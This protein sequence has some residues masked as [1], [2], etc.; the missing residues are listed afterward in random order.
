[1]D[2]ILARIGGLD[3][4]ELPLEPVDVF[5]LDQIDGRATLEELA[6]AT[7]LPPERLAESIL[8][9]ET[10]GLIVRRAKA[11][12]P[13]PSSR[14]S[15]SAEPLR[16]PSAPFVA[17]PEA[18]PAKPLPFADAPSSPGEPLRDPPA[19]PAAARAAAEGP[20][21]DVETLRSEVGALCAGLPRIDHYRLLGVAPTAPFPDIRKR[22]YELVGRY[23][24]YRH[25]SKE[26]GALRDDMERLVAAL[27]TAYETLRSASARAAYDSERGLAPS[28]PRSDAPAAPQTP[29]SAPP[30]RS[31]ASD[32]GEANGS[33]GARDER[34][35]ALG[36]LLRNATSAGNLERGDRSSGAGLAR[37]RAQDGLQRLS[38]ERA[39]SAQA[40]KFQA[41][42]DA[43]L[44]EGDLLSAANALQARL[45]LEPANTALARRA[46]D[47]RRQAD[48]KYSNVYAEQARKAFEEG[49]LGQAAELFEKAGHGAGDQP[50]LL[51]RAAE[52]LLDAGLD[53]KRALRLAQT[54]A[55]GAPDRAGHHML[56]A[57][58]FREAG[59]QQSADGAFRR[60][61][62]L[63]AKHPA[64]LAWKGRR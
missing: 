8:R 49:K 63:D 64:V 28:R 32:A 2:E 33:A 4:R 41:V 47:L 44:S 18:L 56:L 24:P 9:M 14:P 39:P 60:A 1:M 40:A 61:K 20:G 30:G 19:A 35:A 48:T 59:M 26:V 51:A 13:V 12:A 17:A 50:D 57:R 29:S 21:L 62:E 16:S 42:A 15:A 45:S 58:A 7:G 46:A 36:R 53:P 23:H 10:L 55:T 52:C 38:Q 34:R 3:I 25:A 31:S 37:E 54:A 43:A 6:L 22:F 5:V 27:T 11:G